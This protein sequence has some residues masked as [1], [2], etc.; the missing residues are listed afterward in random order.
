MPYDVANVPCSL[1]SDGSAEVTDARTLLPVILYPRAGEVV[2]IAGRAYL[3]AVTAETDDA[4]NVLAFLPGNERIWVNPAAGLT[5][6]EMRA[7][8]SVTAPPDH[9]PERP[10]LRIYTPAA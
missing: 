4:G 10:R 1:R 9:Q 3:P 6:R 5:S 2:L 7:I 8:R